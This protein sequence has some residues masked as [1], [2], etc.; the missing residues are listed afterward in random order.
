MSTGL[1]QYS[2]DKIP[3]T[4]NNGAVMK[5]FKPACIAAKN[6]ANKRR[7]VFAVHNALNVPVRMFYPEHVH[8]KEKERNTSKKAALVFDIPT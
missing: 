6:L 5:D 1:L 7:C 8:V 2:F 3:Y 4:R